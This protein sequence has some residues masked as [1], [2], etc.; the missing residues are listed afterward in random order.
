MVD[1]TLAEFE[2]IHSRKSELKWINRRQ[3]LTRA[4][5]LLVPMFFWLIGLDSFTTLLF[6]GKLGDCR[7]PVPSVAVGRVVVTVFDIVPTGGR[8]PAVMFILE[9]S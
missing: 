2:D 7:C 5:R 4:S 6:S 8:V 9:V 1:L 3:E